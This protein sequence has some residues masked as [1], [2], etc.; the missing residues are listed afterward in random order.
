[1]TEKITPL[2]TRPSREEYDSRMRGVREKAAALGMDAYVA[3]WLENVYYMSGFVYTAQERPFFLIIKDGGASLVVPKLEADHAREHTWI[4]NISYYDEFPAPPG[5]RWVDALRQELSKCKR[6]GIE[7]SLP[8]YAREA[9]SQET[10]VADII[11]ETRLVKSQWELGRVAYAA[12]AAD[13]GIQALLENSS[14]GASELSL[15][16]AGRNAVT[17]KIIQD[18][19]HA[20]FQVTSV[21]AAVWMGRMTAMPHST[22][23]I[24]DAIETG[25]TNVALISLQADGYSAECERTYFVGSPDKKAKALFE[26]MME[27]RN[28]ALSLIKPGAVCSEIDKKVLDFL[29]KKGHA[30]HILHRTGHGFGI[31]SHEAPWIADGSDHVLETDMLV[32]VEPGIYIPGYAGFRHSDTIWVSDKGPVSLTKS[33]TS[34]DEMT[35]V[36]G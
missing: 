7:S 12:E 14:D 13:F 28:I 20:N 5:K 11:E 36:P 17:L 29:R 22:P 2:T 15:Y 27:A 10:V 35:L 26:T 8:T 21:I 33:P 34:L 25:K 32:S 3:T 23:S 9:I 1:L 4:E 16:S 31:G 18:I 6:V 19:P 30:D 24:S